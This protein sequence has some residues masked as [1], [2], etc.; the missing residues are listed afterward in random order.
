MNDRILVVDDE[1][2][3]RLV[4]SDF[5]KKEGFDVIEAENGEVALEKLA[6]IEQ[7]KCVVLDVMMPVMDGWSTLREI[8]KSYSEMPVIMLTARNQIDDEVFGFELGADDYV[9]KPFVAA[10]LIARIK[11]ILRKQHLLLEDLFEYEKLS[12]NKA[13][14]VLTIEGASIELTPKEHEMLEYFIVNKNIA[15]TREKLLD[16]VWGYDY[17]GDIRTVDTHIKRLRIKLGDYAFLIKTV[18]GIGYR[19]EVK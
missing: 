3:L 10:R 2:D 1:R 7:I 6:E 5:L 19:F 9:A 15:L 12:Y 14:C 4:V 8:K 16:Q 18:R 11:S 17:F 13:A